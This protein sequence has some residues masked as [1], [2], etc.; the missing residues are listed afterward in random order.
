MQ[1]K[2][3]CLFP[4]LPKGI[5]DAVKETIESGWIGQ[6]GKLLEF[7]EAFRK[8]FGYKYNYAL[9]SCTSALRMSLALAGVGPNDEVITTPNTFVATN[10]AIR[11][12]FATLIFADIEY[13]TGNISPSSI[14]E[15]ITPKTKAIMIVHWMGLPC[16]IYDIE[17]IA[18]NFHIPIIEDGAQAIGAKY[19]DNYICSG[20]YGCISFQTVKPVNTGDG[21]MFITDKKEIA[22]RAERMSWFGFTKDERRISARTGICN[23]DIKEVGFKYRMNA[24]AATMGLYQ[25]DY[26]DM[27]LAAR[28]AR[29]QF[30]AEQLEDVA[31]VTLFDFR[32][33]EMTGSFYMYPIHVER[34]NKFLKVMQKAGIDAYVHNFRNDQFTVFGGKKNLPNMARFEA[35]YVCLPN[36]SGVTSDDQDYVIK[37]IKRGW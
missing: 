9:N 35:D 26:L 6:T 12:Q 8:K 18:H 16:K 33:Y 17:L 15:K 22:E 23:Y 37:T 24:I 1:R 25:L 10:T 19:Y 11:E 34:R 4:F 7:E 3:P 20:R 32:P 21:G 30:Y 36:H 28:R 2:I 29:A 31:G 14:L 13:E 5:G 27:V